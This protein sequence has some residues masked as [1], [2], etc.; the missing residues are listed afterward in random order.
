MDDFELKQANF[1]KRLD[2]VQAE[3]ANRPASVDEWQARISAWEALL[4]QRA[5]EFRGNPKPPVE[6]KAP[7]TPAGQPPEVKETLLKWV[8]QMDEMFFAQIGLRKYP[9]LPAGFA[10]PVRIFENEAAQSAALVQKFGPAFQNAVSAVIHL[11]G[12]GTWVCRE[13]LHKKFGPHCLAAEINE[14]GRKVIYELAVERWGRGFLLE[15]TA[16]GQ[17]LGRA[18]LYP[19]L[20]LDH[21]GQAIPDEWEAR[22]VRVIHQAW[23]LTESGW[24][25]WVWQFVLYK[26]HSAFG[27][28]KHEHPLSKI[29]EV[30]PKLMMTLPLSINPFGLSFDIAKLIDLFNCLVLD[31]TSVVPNTINAM[32]LYIQRL[33]DQEPRL[34]ANFLHMPVRQYFGRLCIAR[35]EVHVGI[36]PLPY[37]LLIASNLPFAIARPDRPEQFLETSEQDPNLNPDTRLLR[38]S[39]INKQVKH[40]PDVM[41]AA[42]AETLNLRISAPYTAW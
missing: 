13:A 36:H 7:P 30:L 22:A 40:D 29:V 10:A 3:Q 16:L 23:I 8:D 1:L 37:A 18:G 38:L 17:S 33:C 9:L 34:L 27:L 2:G 31:Q 15:F 5:A 24:C 4:E 25:D 35:L 21:L 6:V 11:P 32:V 28:P 42:A 20:G 41:I 12:E 14:A 26:A 39:G 19:A